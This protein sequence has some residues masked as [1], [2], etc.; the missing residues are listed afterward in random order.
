MLE[1]EEL[2]LG[3][4]YMER[5]PEAVAAVTLSA[6]N[7]AIKKYLDPDHLHL[8]ISGSVEEPEEAV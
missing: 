6:A 4:G 3:T 1:Y 8:V 7:N 2:G 5:Y